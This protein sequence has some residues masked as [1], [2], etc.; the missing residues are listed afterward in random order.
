MEMELKDLKRKVD[1]I[2][3]I[4]STS[5]STAERKMEL[6]KVIRKA[7]DDLDKTKSSFKSKQIM[8]IREDLIR[9]LNGR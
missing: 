6:E 9:A 8:Q 5:G 2:Y 3:G 4:L 1:A 7:I